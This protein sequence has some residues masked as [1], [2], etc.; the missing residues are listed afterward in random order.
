MSHGSNGNPEAKVKTEIK[1][2]CD[3]DLK[4][5]LADAAEAANLPL[6]DFIVKRLAKSV[7]RPDLAVIPR[8]KMGRPITRS[9]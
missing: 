6:S 3:P 4:N 5:L 9:A 2:Y 7:G 1:V 8:K